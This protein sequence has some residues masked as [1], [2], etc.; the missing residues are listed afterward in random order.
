VFDQEGWKQGEFANSKRAQALP[1]KAK[2]F[3]VK[4]FHLFIQV[5]LFYLPVGK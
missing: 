2:T 3:I 1:K 4:S 5:A